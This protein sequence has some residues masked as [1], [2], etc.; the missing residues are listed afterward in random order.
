MDDPQHAGA[1]VIQFGPQTDIDAGRV[2]GRVEHITSY[3]AL[4]FS[5]LEELLSFLDKVLKRKREET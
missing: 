4:H 1:F 2:A 3:E 5:S